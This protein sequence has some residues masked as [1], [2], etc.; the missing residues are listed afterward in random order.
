LNILLTQG[1]L[2]CLLMLH[3]PIA[4]DLIAHESEQF[5]L[6]RTY[7]MMTLLRLSILTLL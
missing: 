2:G 1:L 3:A 5:G 7:E 4:P 6:P